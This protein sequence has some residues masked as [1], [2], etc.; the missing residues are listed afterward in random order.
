VRKVSSSTKEYWFARGVG[1][2]KEVGGQ[3]EE[4]VS[5]ELP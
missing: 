1:K 2:V 5:V 4:L 3:T